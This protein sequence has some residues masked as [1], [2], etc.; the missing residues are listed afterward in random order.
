MRRHRK[1]SDETARLLRQWAMELANYLRYKEGWTADQAMRQAWLCQHALEAL[2][3]GVVMFDYNKS[4]GTRRIARGTLCRGKKTF[5]QDG[6][7][8][9][10]C[11]SGFRKTLPAGCKKIKSISNYALINCLFL[12]LFII[13][14]IDTTNILKNNP[15]K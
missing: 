4:D 14:I 15:I 11:L 8:R 10:A 5:Q 1:L 7:Q 12:L 13:N 3:K 6:C 9:T 2:G